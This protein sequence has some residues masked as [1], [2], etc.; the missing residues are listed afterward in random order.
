MTTRR[1]FFWQRGLLV[2]GLILAASGPTLGRADEERKPSVSATVGQL[3]VEFTVQT[4]LI[5]SIEDFA[6]RVVMTN[7]SATNLRLN[8][9]LLNRPKVLL[10]VR[11][12]TGVRVPS[13][14]PGFPPQDDG[15]TGRKVL[16]PSEFV[17]YSYTGLQYFSSELA[18]G[19]YQVRFVYQNTLPQHGDWTGEVETEWVDFEV[20]VKPKLGRR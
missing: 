5:S 6:A 1:Y 13:G 9:L 19:K 11:H 12:I 10:E 7:R 15:E 4:P 3:E 16:R 18:P 17:V 8:C 14:L 20:V 2:V